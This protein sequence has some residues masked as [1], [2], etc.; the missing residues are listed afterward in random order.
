MTTD[1]IRPEAAWPS[2]A[3]LGEEARDFV[4]SAIETMPG[5]L[6]AAAA[7]AILLSIAPELFRTYA[8]SHGASFTARVTRLTFAA[9]FSL[10]HVGLSS[11]VAVTI[12]RFV[13]LGEVVGGFAGFTN[14]SLWI[15]CLWLGALWIA[16][17]PIAVALIYADAPFVMNIAILVLI[18]WI[19]LRIG[20]A[21]PAV[22]IGAPS[23]GLLERVRLSI[24]RTRGKVLKIFLAG[25]V[26]LTPAFAL[27]IG[28]FIA[29]ALVAVL[30][31][32]FSQVHLHESL[33]GARAFLDVTVSPITG[34][35]GIAAGAAVAS[36]A[37]R[38]AL[39]SESPTEPRQ[40]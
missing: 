15:Y 2:A 1:D 11:Y 25:I 5:P 36:C 26:A 31:S 16:G 13:L 24:R 20:L 32:L 7:F 35:F 33:H 28:C 37:Y 22:A 19:M 9:L 6:L 27:A 14:S 40:T 12:H 29:A 8:H 3:K 18:I 38:V 30:I 4:Y 39:E 23:M 10:A 34:I 17:A 21:L